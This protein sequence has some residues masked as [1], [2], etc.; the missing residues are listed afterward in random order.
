VSVSACAPGEVGDNHA[1]LHRT[2]FGCTRLQSPSDVQCQGDKVGKA[3]RAS[4]RV[5]HV[6]GCWRW[7]LPRIGMKGILRQVPYWQVQDLDGYS[8]LLHT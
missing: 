7:L 8:L 2:V 5:C 6:L 1:A 3:T 4:S